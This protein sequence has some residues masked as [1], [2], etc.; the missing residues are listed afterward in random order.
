MNRDD[1][2]EL[3]YEAMDNKQDYDT[4]LHMYAA[5]AVDALGWHPLATTRPEID[6][7]VVCTNGKA[8]WLDKRTAYSPDMKWDGHT[9]THWHPILEFA[10]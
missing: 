5:A 7:V 3:V 1:A 9:P 6:Q 10:P 2:I 8:R 4:T